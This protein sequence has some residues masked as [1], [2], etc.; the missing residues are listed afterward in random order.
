MDAP[1]ISRNFVRASG[2]LSLFQFVAEAKPA[3]LDPA[4]VLS[5][6]LRRI[7]LFA[8]FLLC[9]SEGREDLVGMRQNLLE[10]LCS[11]LSG[12]HPLA[13]AKLKSYQLAQVLQR[14]SYTNYALNLVSL[15]SLAK[16]SDPKSNMSFLLSILMPAA[17]ATLPEEKT[18]TQTETRSH[19]QVVKMALTNIALG[20]PHLWL[21]LRS[22]P[23]LSLTDITLNIIRRL[24]PDPFTHLQAWKHN[25]RLFHATHNFVR[26][27]QSLSPSQ[28]AQCWGTV[29]ALLSALSD[30]KPDPGELVAAL[31]NPILKVYK[32]YKIVH[33]VQQCAWQPLLTDLETL[34]S[35]KFVQQYIN[36]IGTI[37]PDQR[38][39]VTEGF[40]GLC[41]SM[42]NCAKSYEERMSNHLLA[43]GDEEEE[44]MKDIGEQNTIYRST[45]EQNLLTKLTFG[46]E[47]L[48][49]ELFAIVEKCKSSE[50]LINDL[51]STFQLFC[52]L[53][54][55]V[56]FLMDDLEFVGKK[57]A[58][59]ALTQ[60]QLKWLCQIINALVYRLFIDYGS[61][62][63]YFPLR[64][65]ALRLLK[66][67]YDRTRRNKLFSDEFWYLSSANIKGVGLDALLDH[68]PHVIPF[69]KRVDILRHR[70][71][72]AKDQFGGIIS[73]VVRRDMLFEDAMSNLHKLGPYF[74]QMINV[75]FT[76]K[77]GI[78]ET[79]VGHGVFK[80]FITVLS[81]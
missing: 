14:L 59:G 49:S 41:I 69:Q 62:E 19:A 51:S 18:K 39:K 61:T 55:Q 9:V 35:E 5:I 58:K 37:A 38:G 74:K 3:L 8:P 25:K 44:E 65:D 64:C 50:I 80:E 16:V 7:A 31:G 45:F 73:I 43:G 23:Y 24:E 42:I 60:G 15:P 11:V 57:P 30:T 48:L 34:A 32:E 47:V 63:R 6:L 71:A 1:S 10:L 28:T 40:A 13:A 75:Q 26:L 72:E 21:A 4:P 66:H 67:L 81:K 17:F 12:K 29:S 68:I 70:L 53:Y 20:Q 76:N 36:T 27:A 52:K 54:V 2:F 78:I 33:V 79:G 56:L 46:S 22:L 77:D